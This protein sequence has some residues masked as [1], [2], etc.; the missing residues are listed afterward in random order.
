MIDNYHSLKAHH[1]HDVEIVVYGDGEN[2]ALQCETCSEILMDRITTADSLNGGAYCGGSR[3]TSA[4]GCV[5]E[6]GGTSS[7]LEAGGGRLEPEDFHQPDGRWPS[8]IMIENLVAPILDK[9]SG[10]SKSSG[11]KG[12]ESNSFFGAGTR[13][14]S[15]NVGGLGDEGGA[16]RFFK[17][18]KT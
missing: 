3:P 12:G 1:G 4:M 10:I 18:C 6:V 5:G 16:S 8:N 15:M 7:I 14:E 2:V 9:Q 13:A 11:G 17:E